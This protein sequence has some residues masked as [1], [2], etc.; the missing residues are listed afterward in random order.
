M[1]V[2]LPLFGIGLLFGGGIGFAI[3]AGNGI[4]FDGH[5]HADPAHHEQATG[6]GPGRNL[7][8]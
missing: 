8:A 3:A 2:A 6:A 7:A 5:D 4:T 1:N